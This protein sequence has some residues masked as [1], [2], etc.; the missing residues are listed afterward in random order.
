[1]QLTYLGHS[2]FLIK[3]KSYQIVVDPYK[4]GSVPNLKMPKGIVADAVFC[5]HEHGDH[6]AANLIKIKDKPNIVNVV[7]AVVPHDHHN[8]AKRG[9]NKIRMFTDGEYKVVHLGD[10]GCVPSETALEPFKKC[11]VLLAPINGFFT[12]NPSELK[13]ICEIIEPRIVIPMHYFMADKQSGYQDGNMIDSFKTIFTNYQLIDKELN[14]D[15]FKDYK[16]ALIF[17]NYLQ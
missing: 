12:I 9:L 13:K 1:M 3:T 6:N 14:L 2:S 5:S 16:G 4:D 15:D 10:T 8:G 11:D 7:E 17:K